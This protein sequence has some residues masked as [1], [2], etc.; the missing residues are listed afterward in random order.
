MLKM[1]PAVMAAVSIAAFAQSFSPVQPV[2]FSNVTTKPFQVGTSLPGTCA[3]GQLFFKT[4]AATGGKL[5][6]CESANTWVQQ[7]GGGGGGGSIA[8]TTELIKGNGAGGGIAAAAGS[9][10]Y[11]PGL[12]IRSAD[13]PANTPTTDGANTFTDAGNQFIGKYD[14]ACDA[15]GVSADNVLVKI[16]SGTACTALSTSDTG[17]DSGFSGLLLSGHGTTNGRYRKIGVGNCT[18]DNA[19][20]NGDWIIAGTSTGGYC[21]GSSARPAS[22]LLVVGRATAAAL[23]GALASVNVQIDPNSG[24]GGVAV[25]SL[26]TIA[27]GT[28]FFPNGTFPSYT[29]LSWDTNIEDT[30][31]IHSTSVNPSRFTAPSTGWY[32]SVCQVNIDDTNMTGMGTVKIMLNGSGGTQVAYTN[33]VAPGTFGTLRTSAKFHMAANDY[34]ECYARNQSG[35]N[36]DADAGQ[37][38]T[39]MS[40]TKISN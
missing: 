28:A 27:S 31:T 6:G 8:A 18:A 10:Y 34:V 9:D 24:G 29:V 25:H 30:G 20:S 26:A 7:A 35:A 1:I 32:E 36:R 14:L 12:A 38:Y 13:L 39:Y 5:Y 19:I 4:D 37:G 17:M 33:N 40:V 21:R 3:T 15:T 11:K 2:D 16:T 22:G 23:A